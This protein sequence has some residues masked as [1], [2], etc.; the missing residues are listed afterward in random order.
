MQNTIDT[1][2]EQLVQSKEREEMI[3]SKLIKLEDIDEPS[4]DR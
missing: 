4:F 3:E 2:H 1:L